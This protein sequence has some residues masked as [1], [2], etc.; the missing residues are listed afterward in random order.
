MIYKKIGRRYRECSVMEA[1]DYVKG[2]Y[3]IP[4]TMTISSSGEAIPTIRDLIGLDSV[5]NILVLYLNSGNRVVDHEILS[6]GIENQTSVYPK[7]I[8]RRALLKYADGVIISHNHPS[9]SIHPSTADIKI[10]RMIS[11]ALN[12]VEVRFLDHIIITREDHF[13]MRK[14]GMM[15]N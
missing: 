12:T 8:A 7:Q 9:G 13:S 10:T 1:L 4:S 11:D 15:D 14:N 2:N 5:E 3:V 6:T